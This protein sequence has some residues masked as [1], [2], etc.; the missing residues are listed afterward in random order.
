M[1]HVVNQL[2]EMAEVEGNSAP[3]TDDRGP[4]RGLARKWRP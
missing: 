3:L 2:M 4:V 1:S